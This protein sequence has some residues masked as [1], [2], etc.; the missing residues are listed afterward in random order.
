[1]ALTDALISYDELVDYMSLTDS[2]RTNVRIYEDIIQGVSSWIEAKTER[3]LMLR[4][5]AALSNNFIELFNGKE[6]ASAIYPKNWPIFDIVS[7]HDDLN[8]PPTFGAASLLVEGE[9]YILDN[10]DK[11]MIH[12]FVR[13]GNGRQ[14]VRVEYQAGYDPDESERDGG[15]PEALKLLCKEMASFHVNQIGIENISSVTSGQI[16]ERTKSYRSNIP[17]SAME[18][19]EYYRRR[20]L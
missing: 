16:A 4:D 3:R 11:N 5:T 1:M 12:T 6:I 18:I 13:F 20:D 9:D 10:N 17:D 19:L 14:N 7:I 8:L 2:D 15:L